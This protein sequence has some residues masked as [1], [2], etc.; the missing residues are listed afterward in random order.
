MD[1][2]Q[3]NKIASKYGNSFYLFN[4][5]QLIINFK[6]FI[7]AFKS[8]YKRTKIAY[9]YKANYA[10]F[11]IKTIDKLGG[12][13][14]VVSSMEYDIALSCGIKPE[15]IVFNGPLKTTFD[16]KRSLLDKSMLNIDAMYELDIIKKL[17]KNNNKLKN[18][19]KGIGLRL[20]FSLP[21]K[22]VSR[23]GIDEN[24][25]QDAKKQI[26]KI[27][28]IW[29]RGIHCH[30]ST[31]DKKPKNFRFIAE[32][33]IRIYE[34]LFPKHQI[35]YIDTGGGFFGNIPKALRK[36]FDGPIYKTDE[37]ANALAGTFVK[38]FGQN[39]PDL[40]I[41]PGI[42][43]VGD[44]MKYITQVVEIKEIKNHSFV[45][46]S[47]SIQNVKPSGVKSFQPFKVISKKENTDKKTFVYD[48][49]GN[50]CME[51]D[52]LH[53]NYK[54]C[55]SERDFLVFPNKGGYTTVFNPP[56]IHYCP[57]ILEQ[58]KNGDITI[59]KRKENI[60]DILR[61]FYI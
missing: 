16:I 37:Y 61:T 30:F 58:K 35:D 7:Q 52:V 13:A 22:P 24:Q 1:Y 10:P 33:M 8:H 45:I 29:L 26:N 38:Y 40:I 15:K 49:T 12:L 31:R 54:G 11:I 53:K 55:I 27:D 4:R 56:F 39:G 47:G 48:I 41:E 17:C 20:N 14:E 51:H 44:T 46:T 32:K 42:S 59:L 57:P 19:N 21:G 34:S 60:K 43:L 3:I 9:A 28:N 18:I 23:F 36:N 6:N 25:L 50:T 2:T 5:E